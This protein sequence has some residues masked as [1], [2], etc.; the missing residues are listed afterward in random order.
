[1][2]TGRPRRTFGRAK[3]PRQR[4][5][6]PNIGGTQVSLFR[7]LIGE[8]RL[9]GR[10]VFVGA[11]LAALTVGVATATASGGGNS[12]G[13]TACQNGGWHN[14]VGANASAFKNQGDCASYAAQGGPL[15]PKTASQTLCESYGGTF[16]TD[17]ASSYFD[18][19]LATF[20]W[21][22]NHGDM[23]FPND[24]Y[25]ASDCFHDG[26]VFAWETIAAPWYFTCYS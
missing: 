2:T 15:S 10:L 4:S 12:T 8:S 9:V 5:G 19:P 26:G 7:V 3:H 25:Q 11:L 6:E 14:L 20:V 13:A 1:M 21:S 23:T 24:A 17:P 22:C 18:N 16:S